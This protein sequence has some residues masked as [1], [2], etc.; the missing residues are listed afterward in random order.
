MAVGCRKSGPPGDPYRSVLLPAFSSDRLHGLLDELLEAYTANGMPVADSLLPP[1]SEA[2]LVERCR[3]FPGSLPP[4]IVS[5][6][7]WRG[8]QEKEAWESD[9]PFWFRDN[10][11]CSIERAPGEYRRMMDSYGRDPEYHELLKHS[12]PFASFNGGWYVLPTRGQPFSPVLTAPI[13]SV[14]EGIDIHFFSIETMVRT[15]IDWVRA[16]AYD[17]ENPMPRELELQ[18]WR[19]HNPGIF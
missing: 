19:R 15:C 13:I 3:W 9:F 17:P 18:I 5:L 1:L 14:M 12:F 6:Y 4:E 2:E 8:G 16:G 10:T 11:F 7:A